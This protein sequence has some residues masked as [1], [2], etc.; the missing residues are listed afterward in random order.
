MEGKYLITTD[1]WFVAPD[2]RQYKPVWGEVKILEDSFL[3]VKTNR[4]STN[5]FAMIGNDSNHVIIAGCQIY[6]A[7]KSD[8][9]PNQGIVND[10]QTNDTN[11]IV[12][13][14]RPSYTYIAE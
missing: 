1:A 13:F 4:N 11:G 5:W 10:F 12:Y 14:D 8:N 9:K 7:L 3:G 6:Y 2:G